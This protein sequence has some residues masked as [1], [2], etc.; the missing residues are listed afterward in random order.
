METFVWLHVAQQGLVEKQNGAHLQ[1][2]CAIGQLLVDCDTPHQT[3]RREAS[4]KDSAILMV[5][6][7]N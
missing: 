7:G 2:L 1:P 3:L 5:L 4:E 6:H